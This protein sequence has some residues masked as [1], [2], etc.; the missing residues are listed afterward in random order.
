MPTE[1]GAVLR[2]E[3]NADLRRKLSVGHMR[4]PVLSRA[5]IPTLWQLRDADTYM[6]ERDV[7]GMVDVYG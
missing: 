1:R 2:I 5:G 6:F 7:V 3:R 4:R